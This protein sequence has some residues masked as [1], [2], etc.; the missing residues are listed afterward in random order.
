MQIHATQA[1]WPKVAERFKAFGSAHDL[2]FFDTSVTD[3][4]GLHMLN[5]HLCSPKGL[6]LSADKRLWEIGPKDSAPD[7]MPIYLYAYEPSI[8]WATIAQQFEQSF[9]DWSGDVKSQWP[10]GTAV[11]PNTSLESTRGK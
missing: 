10:G 7:E 4:A 9:S 1:E 8:D 2:S 6:W 11:A 3:V 5:V